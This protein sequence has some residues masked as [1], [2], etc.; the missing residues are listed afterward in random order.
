[1][2]R[3]RVRSSATPCKA[4][5]GDSRRFRRTQPAR[6]PLIDSSWSCACLP[7]FSSD[8]QASVVKS[9]LTAAP[10]FGWHRFRPNGPPTQQ[11]EH[12]FVSLVKFRL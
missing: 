2:R 8:D 4:I 11:T 3:N 9:P 10:S 5:F 7:P 6:R 1:M 12:G